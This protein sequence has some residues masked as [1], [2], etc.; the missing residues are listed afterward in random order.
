MANKDK[1]SG[2]DASTILMF[3]VQMGTV[4]MMVASWSDPSAM[5]F[6]TLFA[7]FIPFVMLGLVAQLFVAWVETKNARHR[8]Y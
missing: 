3:F 6:Y 4:S 1:Q 5:E 8:V 2:N 7:W